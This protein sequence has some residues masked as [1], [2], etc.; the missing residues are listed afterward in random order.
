[1]SIIGM[2]LSVM[3]WIFKR[4]LFLLVGKLKKLIDC[5]SKKEKKAKLARNSIAYKEKEREE[6]LNKIK[7]LQ[8]YENQISGT[9]RK[10]HVLN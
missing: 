8:Q 9:R 3:Q 5:S 1:M 4:K 6:I 10:R 7:M 2:C